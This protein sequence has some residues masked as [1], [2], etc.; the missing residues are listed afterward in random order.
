[1]WCY[2]IP[3]LWWLHFCNF[4]SI[5]SVTVSTENMHILQFALW[6]VTS[7][8]P[9]GKEWL[10]GMINQ[11]VKNK[12]WSKHI[13]D[14]CSTQ[15]FRRSNSLAAGCFLPCRGIRCRPSGTTPC[16]LKLVGQMLSNWGKLKEKRPSAWIP[17]TTNILYNTMHYPRFSF[18]SA[19]WL[20]E[21][22]S[23]RDSFAGMPAESVLAFFS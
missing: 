5:A 6:R 14:L 9:S 22:V 10:P 20:G 11:R 3:P 16:L 23:V 8:D 7:R 19:P 2:T 1:M 13:M 12:R 18:L 21:Q 17:T 4:A 15:G